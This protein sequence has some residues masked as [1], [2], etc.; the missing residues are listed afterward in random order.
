[1]TVRI[2]FNFATKASVARNSAL[3]AN[4]LEDSHGNTDF[5]VHLAT[6][7]NVSTR[8]VGLPLNLKFDDFDSV[9]PFIVFGMD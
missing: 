2:D 4:A 5:S 1:M 7:I 6:G 9:E 3:Y 8:K